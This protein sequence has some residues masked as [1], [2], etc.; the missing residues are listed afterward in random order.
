MLTLSFVETQRTSVARYL[1]VRRP[2]GRCCLHK[3]NMASYSVLDV[4]LFNSFY[5]NQ[6]G[7]S[8]DTN[9]KAFGYADDD[10]KCTHKGLLYDK[11]RS[12]S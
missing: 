5:Q 2:S 7:F 10:T 4:R 11:I 9:I 8:A 3:I 12:P 1:D 6:L